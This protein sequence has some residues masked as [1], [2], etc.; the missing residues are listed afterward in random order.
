MAYTH[1]LRREAYDN[2]AV[3]SAAGEENTLN[4]TSG[5]YV[6][7]PTQSYSR[8]NVAVAS[9]ADLENLIVGS[10]WSSTTDGWVE[11]P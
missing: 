10:S 3:G 7:I 4:G 8:D 2:V 9:E 1:R 11:R 5:A 6:K